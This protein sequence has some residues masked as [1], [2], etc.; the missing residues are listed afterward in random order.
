MVLNLENVGK[1]KINEFL[2]STLE[3]QCGKPHSVNIDKIIVENGAVNKVPGI[4]QEMGRKNALVVADSHTFEVAGKKVVELLTASNIK[5][6]VYVYQSEGHLVPDEQAVGKLVLQVEKDTDVI[7]TVGSGSLNDLVKFVSWLIKVPS[8][9]VATAPSMDGYASDTSALIIDNLKTSVTSDYPKIIIGDVDILKQAPMTMILAGLGDII[10]KYSA[11]NDWLISEI[12][13]DE[14][15]CSVTA[16]ISSDAIE[17]CVTNIE[18]IKKREDKAI[19]DLMEGLVRTGIAMSF[20]GNSRPASGCEH[21][22]SH[23]WEMAFLFAGKEALLHGTKVGMSS[24]ITAKLYELLPETKVDF[25]KAVSVARAFDEKAWREKVIAMYGKAAPGILK[26]SEKDGRNSIEKRI[27][28]ISK[29]KENYDAIM[30]IAKA[31]PSAARVRAL[32]EEAGAPVRPKEVGIDDATALNGVIMA[33]EVRPRYSMLNLL[34]DLAILEE[35][36][37]KASDYVK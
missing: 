22:I 33:K 26:L 31:A 25:D 32:M 35:L 18:G 8:L 15:H 37:K 27:A 24:V 5:H 16:K 10:G 34:S 1:M 11:L 3:C 6:K 13:N 17:K 23:F 30:N 19:K 2:G 21:H 20:V 12:V 36:A 4:L 7:V 9:V 29:I 14:Y 28:R